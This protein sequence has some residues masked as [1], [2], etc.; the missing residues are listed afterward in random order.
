LILPSPFF[1]VAPVYLRKIELVSIRIFESDERPGLAFI[2]DVTLKA[3]TL[4]L[5]C[6]D[7]I[8]N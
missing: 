3:N 4:G 1:D 7:S 5:Q 6:A 8:P 2:D